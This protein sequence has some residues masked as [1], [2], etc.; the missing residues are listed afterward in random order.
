MRFRIPMIMAG[1]SLLLFLAAC[2]RQAEPTSQ[3]SAMTEDDIVIG[4]GSLYAGRVLAGTATPYIE[5]NQADYEKAL[6]EDKT[7]LLYFYAN[8]C[9]ICKAE[10][11]DAFAAF[12]QMEYGNVVGFRV[13]Y[14]DSDTD[15]HEEGLAREFGITYQHTKVILKGG[16]R[17]LKAPDSWDTQRYLDE[18][19]GLM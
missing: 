17:V 13:N 4:D 19:R 12:D 6:A 5:F 8:W 16:E 14:R 1:V 3:D 18:I 7:I 15:D 10:E 9:P 11:P 2:A